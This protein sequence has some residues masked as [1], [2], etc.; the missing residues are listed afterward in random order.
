MSRGRFSPCRRKAAERCGGTATYGKYAEA[1]GVEAERN[2][3]QSERED[4]TKRD[5][6]P[7]WQRGNAIAGLL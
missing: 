5:R 1:K 2:V 4:K 6:A 7:T 3:V